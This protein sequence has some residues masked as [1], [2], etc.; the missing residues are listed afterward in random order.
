LDKSI[1]AAFFA[2]MR[3]HAAASSVGFSALTQFPK[4][5]FKVPQD[6]ADTFLTSDTATPL[7]LRP[8]VYDYNKIM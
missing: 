8:D 5:D 2:S 1:P 7:V 6:S 3:L 4:R